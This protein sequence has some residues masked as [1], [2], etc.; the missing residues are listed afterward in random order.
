MDDYGWFAVCDRQLTVIVETCFALQ[1]HQEPKKI[2]RC[3]LTRLA[4]ASSDF[5]STFQA[6]VT[7]H[8]DSIC[9]THADILEKIENKDLPELMKHDDEDP[10]GIL[11]LTP[12]PLLVCAGPITTFGDEASACTAEISLFH[13]AA[14]GSVIELLESCDVSTYESLP[15][16]LREVCDNEKTAVE[17]TKLELSAIEGKSYSAALKL[18]RDADEVDQMD[19]E[20][21]AEAF[22]KLQAERHSQ[23]VSRAKQAATELLAKGKLPAVH[24]A[25]RAKEQVASALQRKADVV[26]SKCGD[27]ET[28]YAGLQQ[29][30]DELSKEIDKCERIRRTTVKVE[31]AK[32]KTLQEAEKARQLAWKEYQDAYLRNEAATIMEAGA[33]F[34]LVINIYIF[35][36]FVL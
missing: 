15:G 1:A 5:L 23:H 18:V 28:L 16:D 10:H 36:R 7:R 13:P 12:G 8:W 22:E 20:K 9:A 33:A 29:Q 25:I 17:G 26:A 21:K 14:E 24:G 11:A 2:A 35:L 31:E 27:A 30:Q 3:S 6:E 19:D 32:R 34:T 4:M